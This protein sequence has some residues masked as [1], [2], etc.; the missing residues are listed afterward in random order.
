MGPPVLGV[1]GGSSHT[2]DCRP[3]TPRREPARWGHPEDCGCVTKSEG[4]G[5]AALPRDR[6][7][8]QGEWSGRESPWKLWT[9]DS[10]YRV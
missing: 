7:V 5:E 6:R 3:E 2:L 4:F 8:I 1:G 9:C 10:R